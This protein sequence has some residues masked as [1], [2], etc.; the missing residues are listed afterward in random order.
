MPVASVVEI[1]A[2]VLTVPVSSMEVSAWLHYQWTVSMLY[3]NTMQKR[4]G[5]IIYAGNLSCLEF[6]ECDTYTKISSLT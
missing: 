6:M 3:L 4:K 1:I 5:W 2:L